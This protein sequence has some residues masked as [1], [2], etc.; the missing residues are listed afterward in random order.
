MRIRK[1]GRRPGRPLSGKEP[2]AERLTVMIPR[3]MLD[4]LEARAQGRVPEFV[5]GAIQRALARRSTRSSLRIG[6]RL[7]L[8][9]GPFRGRRV[10][11]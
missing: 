9:G 3:S 2:L 5:R 10:H 8:H 11:R 4:A 1:T 6:E 7:I